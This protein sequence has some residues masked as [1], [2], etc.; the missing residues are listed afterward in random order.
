MWGHPLCTW[1]YAESLVAQTL[2]CQPNVK[3]TIVV[4]FPEELWSK[5]SIRNCFSWKDKQIKFIP[6][7]IGLMW[8]FLIVFYT[9]HDHRSFVITEKET[10]TCPEGQFTCTNGQCI[11][12]RLVC[13]KVSDCTDDSDEPLHCN[14]DE[15]ARVEV[16]QCGHKCVNTLTGF[17]CECNTGYKSV[18][19]STLHIYNLFGILII[20]LVQ[21]A[22]DRP[23]YVCFMFI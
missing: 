12:Y 17:Y 23:D 18:V 14:V 4:S 11:D 1:I 19:F 13:N 16:H 7:Q 21:I 22:R 20:S 8:P 15:C 10:N 5:L 6:L 2:C 9:K 3:R